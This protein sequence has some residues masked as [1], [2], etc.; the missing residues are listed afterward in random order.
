MPR[1]SS[2]AGEVPSYFQV[3]EETEAT[4]KEAKRE[5]KVTHKVET[6]HGA[7]KK[8]K[9]APKYTVREQADIQSTQ[10]KLVAKKK[11]LAELPARLAVYSKSKTPKGEQV[12]D[13]LLA[14]SREAEAEIKRLNTELKARET[15]VS[16]EALAASEEA[17]M[18]ITTEAAEE[19]EEAKD[20]AAEQFSQSMEEGKLRAEER[21][22]REDELLTAR[23]TKTNEL[24]AAFPDKNAMAD[25]WQDL[26]GVLDELAKNDRDPGAVKYRHETTMSALK[27]AL[28]AGIAAKDKATQRELARA[29]GNPDKYFNA[30]TY[31]V[32]GGEEVGVEDSDAYRDLN[33]ELDA[34]VAKKDVAGVYAFRDKI[35]KMS[36]GSVSENQAAAKLILDKLEE[37]E[38]PGT[39]E[40]LT[41]S[42]KSV[43]AANES[44]TR[45]VLEVGAPRPEKGDLYG[46]RRGGGLEETIGHATKEQALVEARAK[47]EEA[48]QRYEER[49]AAFR[50][51][52]EES[53]ARGGFSKQE[54]EWFAEG[55]SAEY[56]EIQELAEA[57]GAVNIREAVLMLQKKTEVGERVTGKEAELLDKAYKDKLIKFKAEDFGKVAEQIEELQE[58]IADA[59]KTSWRNRLGILATKG[60]KDLLKQDESL[61][62]KLAGMNEDLDGLWKGHQTTAG[63]KGTASRGGDTPKSLLGLRG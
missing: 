3:P 50:K 53:E 42:A 44:K 16:P 18:E 28:M 52:K 7:P 48:S 30:L 58:K 38:T 56:Q 33:K 51:E 45:P 19:A 1:R 46:A 10:R 32:L 41:E 63:V 9:E 39:E 34:L 43:P 60:L 49:V 29:A 13:R 47:A 12:R 62:L 35:R 61:R 2:P 55:E 25:K 14:E 5:K 36:A 6:K 8:E 37:A 22:K 31:E 24:V 59:K 27:S 11:R 20:R 54:A 15:G 21:S 17:E 40:I 57:M 26:V 4:P 23:I